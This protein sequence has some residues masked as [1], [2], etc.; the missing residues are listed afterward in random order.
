[1]LLGLSL[2]FLEQP[3]LAIEN[4]ARDVYRSQVFGQKMQN[5]E[6][7]NTGVYKTTPLAKFQPGG[8]IFIHEECLCFLG[9]NV[10]GYE[11]GDALTEE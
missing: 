9:E 2:G 5:A 10:S 11:L 6:I 8:L 3:I 1:M 4:E 7:L